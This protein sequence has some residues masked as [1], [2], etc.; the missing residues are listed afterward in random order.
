MC[1]ADVEEAGQGRRPRLVFAHPG[2]HADDAEDLY[3][4]GREAGARLFREQL[5]DQ[6]CIPDLRCELKRLE[7][8]GDALC[9][10][11]DRVPDREGDFRF[12]LIGRDTPGV[13][14]ERG[15]VK[16]LFEE[17]VLAG[18]LEAMSGAVFFV[19]EVACR[20]GG[21]DRCLFHAVPIATF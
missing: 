21:A 14:L 4:L 18:M 17:G 6:P 13:W 9:F 5:A 10:E 8:T 3:A 1:T 12:D 11:L 16:C 15:E 7:P 20:G 19:E 2:V